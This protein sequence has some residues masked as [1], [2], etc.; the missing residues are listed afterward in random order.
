[1]PVAVRAAFCVRER[2]DAGRAKSETP[3]RT[4]PHFATGALREFMLAVVRPLKGVGVWGLV[5][6][7]SGVCAYV[8]LCAP[9]VACVRR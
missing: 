3:V 8:G 6:M 4:R 9:G 2:E 7:G 5:F 1:M